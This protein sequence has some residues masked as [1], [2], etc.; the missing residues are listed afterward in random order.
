[1]DK[2]VALPTPEHP[3]PFSWCIYPHSDSSVLWADSLDDAL[4]DIAKTMNEGQTVYVE[5]KIGRNGMILM[6]HDG[7]LTMR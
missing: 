5:D 2:S 6:K 1:M 4:L 7:S 3:L